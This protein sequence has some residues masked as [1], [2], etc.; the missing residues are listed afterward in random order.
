MNIYR[1]VK[2]SSW[3]IMF[4]M[5]SYLTGLIVDPA[6]TDWYQNIYKSSLTPPGIVFGIV[7]TILYFMLA[8][9]CFYLYEGR[10]DE[11]YK[12]ISKLFL[13]QILLNFLW[14]PIFFGL[15]LVV[16]ALLFLLIIDFCNIIIL[17]LSF[18]NQKHIFYLMFPYSIWC[19]FATYLSGYI[20]LFN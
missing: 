19:L 7:W 16:I 20:M 13:I 3:I 2:L 4:Q 12:L 9:V 1:L 18:K 6:I 17:L 15:H 5:I 10:K 11:S 8:I 14:T